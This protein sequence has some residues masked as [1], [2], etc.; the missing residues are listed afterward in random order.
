MSGGQ[1]TTPLSRL[2]PDD[3][4]RRVPQEAARTLDSEHKERMSGER[5]PDLFRVAPR[6][7]WTRLHQVLTDKERKEGDECRRSSA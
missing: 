7:L 2:R 1:K 3:L 6:E 5:P 4:P